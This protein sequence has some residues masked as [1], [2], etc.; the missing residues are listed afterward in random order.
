MS[1][2]EPADISK[3]LSVGEVAKRSGVAVSAI[4][5]YEAKGLITSLRNEGNQRRYAR[6]V[7]RRVAVIKVAQRIGIS[8]AS[9]HEALAS[10]PQGRTPNAADWARLSR[11]W[12]QELDDRITKLTQLRD[13]MN[14]CIGCGC[15]S[16]DA[17]RLRNPL[18]EL[19]EQG[20]G[21]RLLDPVD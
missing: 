21:A 6:D 20:A 5:F 3:R 17:C 8:L 18:D 9:I 13:Q 2:I 11:R 14:D 4:H 10:L 12:Q 19:S 7:L 1:R 16:I 15:L